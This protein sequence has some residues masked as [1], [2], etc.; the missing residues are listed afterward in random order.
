MNLRVAILRRWGIIIEANYKYQYMRK[1]SAKRNLTNRFHIDTVDIQ[2]T[3]IYSSEME[4][5]DNE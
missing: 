1:F 4:S 5:S 3:Y 2:Y